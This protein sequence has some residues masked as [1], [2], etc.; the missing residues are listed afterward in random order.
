MKKILIVI[1]AILTAITLFSACNK[2]DPE[3]TSGTDSNSPENQGSVTLATGSYVVDTMADLLALEVKEANAIVILKGYHSANDGGGGTFYFD[4]DS[5]EEADGSL[6]IKGANES[7]RFIRSYEQNYV[8]VKWFGAT[9]DGKTDDTAA[10]QAAIDS[11]VNGG[12]VSFPAGNYAISSTLKVGN[13]DAGENVSTV[14]GIKLIGQGGGFSH[15]TPSAT[16]IKAI[17]QMDIMLSLNGRISDCEIG[18]IYFAGNDRAKTCL[19]L[20][21]ISGGYFHNVKAMGFTEVGIKVIAGNQPTG[22]YNIYNRFESINSTC[23]TDNTTAILFDGNYDAHN[24]TWLTVVSDCRFDTAQSENSI[25]A[26]FKFVDSISFY[27]CHFNT[28]KSSSIGAVFDA[29]DND[30]F[31]CG[32]AFHDCSMT[33]HEVWEDDAHN[34]RKQYFYGF[35]TYDNEKIPTHNKLI[36][37]TDTGEFFNIDSIDTLLAFKDSASSGNGG[38]SSDGTVEDMGEYTLPAKG[39]RVDLYTQGSDTHHN[40]KDGDT[41]AV[42]INAK[43]NLTG[44]SF[45][46]SSYDN[47][48]GTIKFDVYRWD[49]DYATTVKGEILATDSA[50][51]FNNNTQFTAQFEGLSSG[52][53]LIVISGSTTPEDYGIAVWTKGMSLTTLTF[54][55]G[56]LIAAGIRGQFITD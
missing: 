48:V 22:N 4:A 51:N 9:G 19:Y 3:Q 39:G 31:P 56:E 41:L 47:N 40:L 33:S 37:I 2:A 13:G 28:Y 45:Y 43:G 36:G 42:L 17:A 30:L 35:G 21:A 44:G 27:R 20:S 26:H 7:G 16:T 46:L 23:L 1:I 24:D 50:V 32:M 14:H 15:N 49:T 10:I 11:L 5:T 53:Y 8:N 54:K 52:Y 29:L 34:I 25:G 6:V 12:T 38:N 18:G 55:N